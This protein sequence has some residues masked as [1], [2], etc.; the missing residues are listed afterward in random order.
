MTALS[1]TVLRVVA[2]C[3]ALA[4]M[5][6]VA[7]A[8]GQDPVGLDRAAALAAERDRKAEASA[9]PERSAIERALYWYDNQRLIPQLF[10]GWNGLHVAGGD[11]PAG[12]GFAL[13]GGFTRGNRVIVN[14]AGAT[15]TNGYLRGAAS[16]AMPRVAGA[17]VDIGVHAT[18]YEFP[19]ED[20]FGLGQSSHVDD[21]TDY[22]LNGSEVGADV[23]WR[24]SR[25]VEVWGGLA[26]MRPRVREG[27]DAAYP[28]TGEVFD[29]DDLAGFTEQP[30][31][32]RGDVSLAFDWRDNPRHPH[33]GGRYRIGFSAFDDR[34]L[35][36]YT[37]QRVDVEVQQYVPLPDQYRTLA[38]RA[39]AT[40]TN[41]GEGDEVPFY[42]QPSLGGSQTLRGFRE[43]RFRD[44]HSLA[45]GA[46]YRWEA[47][48]ALDGALF[49]DAGMVAPDRRAFTLRDVDVTYG[50][51]FR[52]HSN[53]A[54]AA[55]L[56]LAFSREGFIPLL[57]F[58]HVF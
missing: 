14:L 41:A 1:S 19:Q 2:L 13:G 7:L 45:M 21:R 32:L 42:A 27:T 38:L 58:D 9:P 3:V 28:G 57:R 43:F 35:N 4:A 25:H 33:A 26:D 22:A 31:Y 17:P 34:D 56:D 10:A 37:F 52:F 53:K 55:R 29:A 23:R 12:A 40:F 39:A 11:F 49:V 36:A 16:V 15:S 50:V 8:A 48:W 18:A 46:E 24:A 5:P 44:R 47:W 54:F 20:F 6:E 30:R 51:G